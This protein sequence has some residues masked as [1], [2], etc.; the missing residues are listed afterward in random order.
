MHYI[1]NSSLQICNDNKLF[2]KDRFHKVDKFNNNNKNN[3]AKPRT[4]PEEDQSLPQHTCLD[5]SSMSSKTFI[6]WF[7]CV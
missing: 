1:A 2:S 6:G 3:T 5:V 7:G 4:G